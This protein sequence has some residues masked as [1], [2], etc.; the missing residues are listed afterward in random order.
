MRGGGRGEFLRSHRP[1]AQ[2]VG[3]VIRRWADRVGRA[4]PPSGAHRV[5]WVLR[6]GG[7]GSRGVVCSVRSGTGAVPGELAHDGKL[8]SAN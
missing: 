5:F 8:P 3:Q 2:E 1:D 7:L 4:H 6:A